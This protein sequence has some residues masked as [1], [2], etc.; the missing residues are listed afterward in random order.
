MRPFYLMGCNGVC[1]KFQLFLCDTACGH[2]QTQHAR[3]AALLRIASKSSG[4]GFISSLVHFSCVKSVGLFLE[5]LQFLAD[6]RD[7]KLFSG[8]DHFF[9][10]SARLLYSPEA[11]GYRADA[12]LLCM[13]GEAS[14]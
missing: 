14:L 12:G 9:L 13:N 10:I 1:D 4:K 3:L 7:F 5:F 11:C 6:G 8:F 2:A